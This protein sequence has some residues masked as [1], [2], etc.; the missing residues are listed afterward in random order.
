MDC[1]IRN[2]HEISINILPYSSLYSIIP[3][4]STLYYVKILIT[5]YTMSQLPTYLLIYYCVA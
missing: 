2:V 1:I 3:P 4:G 5:V